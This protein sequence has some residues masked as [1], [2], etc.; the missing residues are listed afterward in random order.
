MNEGADTYDYVIVGAGSAG[1]V[2]ASRLTEDGRASV[3][4]LEFGGSDRSVF[5]QMPAA[6]SIPMNMK[7]Y[8]WGYESEPEPHLGGRRLALPARQGA[9]RLVLDQRPRLCPRQSARFR[10]L[11]GGG[12]ATAGPIAMCCPISAAPRAGARAPT[13][14]AAP[15]GRWRRRAAPV[16]TRSTTPSSKRAGRPAIPSAPDL[17]GEQQEGF[18]RFDMTVKDG[19]RWSAANAYLRPAMKRA[20]LR[21]ADPRAGDAKSCSRGDARSAFATSAAGARISR[22]RGAR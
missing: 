3:L 2:L 19:V 9:R 15:T 8:N 11:G 14:I 6:L 12:R 16:A 1:C 13:P 10:P 20:N 17:N 22:A 18:G 5:I 4:V 21:V 7:R